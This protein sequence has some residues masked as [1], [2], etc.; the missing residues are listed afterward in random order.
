M[1]IGP[2]DKRIELQAF[3]AV[4]DG[5]GGST[6]TWTTEDTTWAAIWPVS[7]SE[8][9]RA[10][11]PTMTATHRIQMRYREELQVKASW[12]VKYGARYFSIVSIIN[13]DEKNIQL[14]LLCRE[15]VQ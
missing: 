7:A 9:I 10:Q 4:S 1:R 11:S 14:D 12:R 13:K 5:M 8:T 2:M 15:V 6:K 3:T